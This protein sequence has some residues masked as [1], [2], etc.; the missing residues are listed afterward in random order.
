VVVKFREAGTGIDAFLQQQLLLF[1]GTT[2]ARLFTSVDPETMA[3]WVAKAVHSDPGYTAPDFTTYYAFSCNSEKQALELVEQLSIRKT[4]ELAYV[5]NGFADT[6][7]EPSLPTPA[8]RL[9]AHH[10]PRQGYLQ[11]APLGI[12]A[13][14]AWTL[15]GG[16]GEGNVRFIDIEQGW[17]TY[18]EAVIPRML[19]CTGISNSRSEGHGTAVLGVLTMQADD[20]DITGIVPR[21]DGY[22]LSQWRPGGVFNTADAI[23]AAIGY[24][25][26]GDVLL[27]EAQT[28][29]SD[30]GARTWPIEIHEANYQA[31]RLAS[32]L[33]IIVI[34]PAGNGS[35]H[36][37]AGNDL[38]AFTL[39]D[40]DI[41]NPAGDHFRDSGAIMVAAAT[42]TVPH[43][44]LPFSNY[45]R[46][47]NCYAWGEAVLTAG[48]WPRHPGIAINTYTTGFGGTSAAAAIVAG[49]AIA[50]QSIAEAAHRSR[51]GPRQMRSLLADEDGCTPSAGGHEDKIGV[52]PDLK[53]M[54]SEALRI[55]PSLRSPGKA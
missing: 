50:L 55:V 28:W 25:Q 8:S 20:A 15:P 27:L 44:R 11:P 31:I 16:R 4:V 6:A 38:D 48:S 35:T 14:Y 47:V 23:M 49:A 7:P 34:E 2:A 46:R 17:M 18:H 53:R 43:I 42:H 41:L 30:T 40:K 39:D 9:Q 36:G 29:H 5:E 45:G 1:P 54:V 26:W 21:A 19:A 13:C 33:G 12:D 52:M 51:L 32:A 24:L 22:V 3:A 10:P 37:P